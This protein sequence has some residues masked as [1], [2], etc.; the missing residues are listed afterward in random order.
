M[1]WPLIGL[2]F[3]G[4]AIATGFPIWCALLIGG[5][6]ITVF[7]IGIPLQSVV[8]QF[9]I[10]IDSWLL[11]AV[12]YFLLAGNLMTHF[13]LAEKLFKFIENL[14]GHLRGGLPATGVVTCAIFG[15]LSGSSTAT[16]VAV[17]AMLLPHMLA[18]G[19]Q[20]QDA[21]G[22]IAVSGTLGQMIPPSIYMILFA[23]LV[24]LDVSKLFLAGIVPGLLIAV[25]LIAT[26]VILNILNPHE[27]RPRASRADVWQ[28]FL[29]AGPALAMPAIVLGG[30]YSGIFTPTEAAAVA[31]GYVILVSFI[32]DRDKFTLKN[33]E[34]CAESA[35]V[36]TTVVFIILGGASVFATALTFAD[37]PQSFVRYAISLSVGDT[38][39]MLIIL[40]VFLVLGTIL[41]P[42]PI[43]Y[44]TIP[45]LYPV[46][47]QIGFPPTQF[48]ILTVTCM[49]IAQVTPPIGVSLFALS[50][51]FN[52]PVGVV[53]RGAA[54]YL[55]TLV[56]AL[57]I[58]WIFPGISLLAD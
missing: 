46:V 51:F 21:L 53:A 8:S 40:S 23:S 44:I 56:L 36:T 41:D 20:K 37:V 19:Y 30:I 15:A 45:I 10:S 22:V 24:Q 18:A 29:S 42:V 28:S 55:A 47:Q 1:S 13:G 58:L 31:V 34:K 7:G 27:L 43:L 54:P 12:P 25:M 50:G 39:M 52:T 14:L 49:M 17:G 5:G 35:V 6:L 26:A 57:I 3:F 9:Y 38:T 4:L 48:A 11:L 33:F 2:S 16:V 32:F